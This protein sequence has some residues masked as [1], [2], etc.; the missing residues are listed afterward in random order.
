MIDFRIVAIPEPIINHVHT[1]LT[2]PV[3]HF[4]VQITITGSGDYG[5][6]RA[7]LNTFSFGERR[8]HFLYNPFSGQQETESAEPILIHAERCQPYD[9]QHHF[10]ESVRTLPISVH[11]YDAHNQAVAEERPHGLNVEV[12]IKALL[13]R[14]RVAF[15]HVRNVEEQLFILHIARDP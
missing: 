1:T 9:R 12:A 8:I 11:G 14:N 10:P 7:C 15:L 3:Y 2:D 5:P 13:R 4:P 6:C